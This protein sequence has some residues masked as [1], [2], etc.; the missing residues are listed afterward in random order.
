[1]KF[2]RTVQVSSIQIEHDMTTIRFKS[3]HKWVQRMSYFRLNKEMILDAGLHVSFWKAFS[4]EK[5]LFK[6][7]L[8]FVL[9]T[10]DQYEDGCLMFFCLESGIMSRFGWREDGRDLDD[11]W[12]QL[13]L[14]TDKGPE[15]WPGDH[16]IEFSITE[17]EL[18]A[19]SDLKPEYFVI[20]ELEIV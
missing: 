16:D 11:R 3:G 9:E 18:Q 14:T 13:I 1:M 19:L 20:R 15:P 17:E 12:Y 8:R 5:G 4:S 2:E 6:Y 7:S 10:V